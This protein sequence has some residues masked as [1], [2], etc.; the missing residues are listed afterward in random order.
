MDYGQPHNHQNQDVQREEGQQHV[1]PSARELM[2]QQSHR[3]QA[4]LAGL[5]APGH[6]AGPG[7]AVAGAG[8]GGGGVASTPQSLATLLAGSGGGGSLA[9][10]GRRGGAGKAAAGLVGRLQVRRAGISTAVQDARMAAGARGHVAARQA[11]GVQWA[12][13]LPY[14][15]QGQGQHM[16]RNAKGHSAISMDLHLLAAGTGLVSFV[17]FLIAS[18][19]P[20]SAPPPTPRSATP[21]LYWQDSRRRPTVRSRP[22]RPPP[23]HR[24]HQVGSPLV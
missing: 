1:K 12:V 19:T 22:R 16:R 14:I 24:R 9:V 6:A 15:V 21:R 4:F 10:A 5:G 2:Q 20:S 23:R 3:Q 17:G 8:G 13:T 11:L 7:A 18:Q